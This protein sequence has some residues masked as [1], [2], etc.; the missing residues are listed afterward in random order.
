MYYIN[1]FMYAEVLIIV[2][3]LTISNMPCVD[4]NFSMSSC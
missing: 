3:N 2:S 1:I 4:G